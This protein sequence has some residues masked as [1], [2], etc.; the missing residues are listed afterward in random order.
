MSNDELLYITVAIN[1]TAENASEWG[2][3]YIYNKH[4]NEFHH[5]TFPGKES[6]GFASWFEL[7]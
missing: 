3:D 5:L 7:I 6:S 4:T 1:E 2:R